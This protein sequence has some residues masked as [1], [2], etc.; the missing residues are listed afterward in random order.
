MTEEALRLLQKP[1]AAAY[2]RALAALRDDTRSWWE[3]QLGW[4]VEDYD[5]GQ[6]PFVAEP[7]A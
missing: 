4:D 2:P 3:D 6:T 5:E 1:S 7:T